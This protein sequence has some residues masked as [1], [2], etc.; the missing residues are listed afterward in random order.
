[1]SHSPRESWQQYRKRLLAET[2]RFIEWGLRHPELVTWIPAKP[3]GGG[4]FPRRV[5]EWFWQAALSDGSGRLGRW[6]DKLLRAG[7]FLQRLR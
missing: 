4:G 1:M 6:R 7:L 2:S 5:A 3:V